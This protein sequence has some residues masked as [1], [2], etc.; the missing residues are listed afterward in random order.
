[1]SP[2][3]TRAAGLPR[4]LRR[5]QVDDRALERLVVHRERAVPHHAARP[6]AGRCLRVHDERADLTSGLA[7]GAKSGT[8]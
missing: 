6:T 1:M 3:N 4:I 8:S 2:L 7:V 5:D